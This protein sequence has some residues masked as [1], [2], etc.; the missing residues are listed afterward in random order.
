MPLTPEDASLKANAQAQKGEIGRAV[1]D[2]LRKQ[3]THGATDDEI[4]QAL[5]LLHQTVSARRRDLVKQGTVVNSGKRRLTRTGRGATVWIVSELHATT[6]PTETEEKHPDVWPIGK[7][8]QFT[9]KVNEALYGEAYRVVWRVDLLADVGT[10]DLPSDPNGFEDCRMNDLM[11]RVW[12][13]VAHEH[14]APN[15]EVW[16]GDSPEAL[17]VMVKCYWQ[18]TYQWQRVTLDTPHVLRVAKLTQQ[19]PPV[20]RWSIVSHS[21]LEALGSGLPPS[22]FF[23]CIPF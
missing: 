22:F 5:D 7:A 19:P 16:T 2:Y 13:Y 3:G 8:W 10:P 23:D 4:E 9:L 14:P 11:N 12:R 18:G 17:G 1:L 21:D 20:G 15:G 6:Q